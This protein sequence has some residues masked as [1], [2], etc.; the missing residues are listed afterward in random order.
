MALRIELK[1]NWAREATRRYVG[2]IEEHVC[3]C[4]YAGKD[5]ARGN[6]ER[7]TDIGSLSRLRRGDAQG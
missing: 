1:M 6:Q 7:S 5:Y 4:S 3:S 2:I